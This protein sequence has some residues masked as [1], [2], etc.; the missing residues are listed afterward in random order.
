M[1]SLP[2]FVSGRTC[3]R[4]TPRC[5]IPISKLRPSETFFSFLFFSFFISFVAPCLYHCR[6]TMPVANKT[7]KETKIS[8]RPSYYL[9]ISII[10]VA[11]LSHLPFP[12]KRARAE[13]CGDRGLLREKGLCLMLYIYCLASLVSRALYRSPPLSPR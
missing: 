11:I 1:P 8:S 4:C 2:H 7:E 5:F 10:V 6:F 12:D 13:T 9:F 3:G